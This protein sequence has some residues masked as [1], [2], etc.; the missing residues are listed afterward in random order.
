MKLL[1]SFC[2][3]EELHHDGV[4]YNYQLRL[5]P[6]HTI[7]RAHFP[8]QPI[9]PGVCVIQ[10]AVELLEQALGTPWQ[11]QTVV[12]AK[13][14]A[15]LTPDVMKVGVRLDRI[16]QTDDTLKAQATFAKGETTFARLTVVCTKANNLHKG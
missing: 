8:D 9:T 1:N 10:I 4:A 13:F 7:F 12:N 15:P 16:A 5:N 2:A 6:D 14:L 11:L 3:I